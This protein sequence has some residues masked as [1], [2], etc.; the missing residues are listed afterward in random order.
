MKA[1]KWSLNFLLNIIE[2]DF[3]N[4]YILWFSD[5]LK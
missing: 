4:N 5:N 1:F 2:N 3:I